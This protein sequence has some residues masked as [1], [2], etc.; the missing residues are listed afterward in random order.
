MRESYKKRIGEW[1]V[2]MEWEDGAESGGPV[3]LVIEPVDLTSPPNGGLSSTVLR[4]VDFQEAAAKLGSFFQMAREQNRQADEITGRQLRTALDSGISD[5]YLVQL[6]VMYSQVVKRGRDHPTEYLAELIG[7]SA[8]TIKGH[9][10]QAKKKGLFV[11]S[12][13]RVGGELTPEGERIF[14]G[15]VAAA[16]EEAD[17]RRAGT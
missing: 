1:S 12:A 9:L 7:K 4:E 8:S 15:I 13:G 14:E 6:C 11:G 3:R 2:L 17:K 5:E 16:L 10:W